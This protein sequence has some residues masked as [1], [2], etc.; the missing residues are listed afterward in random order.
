MCGLKTLLLSISILTFFHVQASHIVGGEIQYKYLGGT[1]YKLTFKIYRD[2][3]STTKYDGDTSSQFTSKFYFGIFEG[4]VDSNVFPDTTRGLMLLSKKTI[5]PV[6]VHNCLQVNNS[7]VEEGI[8]E[9]EIEL[10][11]NDVGYTIIHQRCCRNDDILNIKPLPGGNNTMPGF[12]IKCFIPPVATYANNSPIFKNFPPIFICRDQSFYFDHGATDIDGDSLRYFLSEPLDGLTEN[13]PL[14]SN[15]SLI[16]MNKIEWETGYS[17]ANMLGGTPALTIDSTTGFLSCRPNK[18]GRFVVSIIVVE[19]RNGLPIDTINRDFQFNVVDCDIPKADMPFQ[20][21]TMNPNTGIGAYLYTFCDTFFVQFKNT[22]SNSTLYKWDFGDPSTG[23][24]NYSQLFEPSHTYSDTGIFM[25]KLVAYKVRIAGDTCVDSTYRYVRVYPR[26]RVLFTAHNACPDSP[27]VFRDLTSSHYGVTQKWQWNFGDG[28]SSILQNPRH[29]YTAGGN[30]RVT[31]VATDSKLCIDDTSYTLTIYQRPSMPDSLPKFCLDV[32]DTIEGPVAI[33]IP[34][35]IISK[36]WNIFHTDIA[37]PYLIYRMTS[38][39]P[40]PVRLKLRTDKG[41]YFEKDYLLKAYPKPNPPFLQDSYFV[42]C[43]KE[44]LCGIEDPYAL[45]YRWHDGVRDSVRHLSAKGW[46]KVTITYPC[47]D[48]H[49]S[50]YLYRNH[51]KADFHFDNKCLPDTFFFKNNSLTKLVSN[52]K[53]KWQI[54]T[55][56][57]SGINFQY[58]FPSIKSLPVQLIV[59]DEFDCSDT[60]VKMPTIYPLPILQLPAYKVCK[61]VP[62]KMTAPVNLPS[63]YR[64]QQWEWRIN[65]QVRSID[66]QLVFTATDY[67]PNELSLIIQTDKGCIDSSKTWINTHPVPSPIK[68]KDS[69]F[70]RCADSLKIDISDSLA[71]SYKWKDNNS[72]SIRYID[73]PGKFYYTIHY[74]CMIYSDSI[75]IHNSCTINV[76]SA[77]TP[78]GDGNNDVFYIRGYK[79]KR[80]LS[81]KIF[82]RQGQLLFVSTNQDDGWDGY[83]KGQAQNSET[84]YYTYEAETHSKGPI[85]KGEGHFLLLR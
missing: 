28:N 84:Y 33:N 60:I 57:D 19:Y 74:P 59:Y 9:T 78:N 85:V 29:A 53:F 82:N 4:R 71:L 22:S 40:V 79:V 73:Y 42:K 25:V 10:P 7:C 43:H 32:E 66:S 34:D 83:Y 1:R 18:N 80:L 54:A 5:L 12:T 38:D 17:M 56:I 52:L 39:T 67:N 48:H 36:K 70:I 2:C 31:L 37:T 23:L 45:K 26:F 6:I 20:Q 65:G 77:F 64:I 30:Y 41:C 75:K 76:P 47:E 3:S 15:Q 72:D 58:K 14:S 49:D 68:L 27:V 61:D 44:L 50:F 35:T 8:Y 16:G 24:N 55:T 51:I 69:F 21:G 11:R 63:P 81:F 13:I 62:T 46:Y